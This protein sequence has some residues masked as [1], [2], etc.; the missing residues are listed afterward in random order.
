[1]LSMYDT[2]YPDTLIFI[3]LRSVCSLSCNSEICRLGKVTRRHPAQ[4]AVMGGLSQKAWPCCPCATA[5]RGRKY[6]YQ[7]SQQLV[8]TLA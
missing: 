6:F 4:A 3:T 8:K 5:Q 2:S 7:I 1:M